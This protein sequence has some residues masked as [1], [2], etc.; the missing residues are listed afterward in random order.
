MA[1]VKM[2]Y[3]HDS[4]EVEIPDRNL[5]DVLVPADVPKSADLIGCL[6]KNLE[7]PAGTPAFSALCAGRRKVCVMVCD[8]TRP[9]ETDKILPTM[10]DK[11]GAG[12][13]NAEIVILVALGTHRPLSEGEIDRVVGREIGKKYAVVNHDA[14]D[15]SRL[16]AVP[17][18]RPD[19]P[20]QV[21]SLLVESDFRLALGAVK[22]HPVFGWSGGGK[23]VIP[24]VSGHETIGISHW[25]SCPFK[26]T[27]IMGRV[28][29]PVR[30]EAEAIV[31]KNNLLD[32]VVNAVLD[33]NGE[34]HDLRCGD[35][36][37]AHRQ[38]VDIARR[39]Y[40]RDIPQPAD[41][42]LVGAGKWAPDLW[43]GSMSV[44]QSEFFVKKGGTIVLFGNFP[45]GVGR[46][47]PEILEWGYRPYR[48]V[49]KL[50]EGGALAN[51]LTLAAHLVHLGR[52]LD[53]REAKCLLLSEGISPSDA[54]RLGFERLD[55][56]ERAMERLYRLHGRDCRVLA[57]PGFNSTPIVS[58]HPVA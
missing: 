1:I 52:V 16:A 42:V 49:K 10:L 41:A 30:L 2:A 31:A 48:E 6:G 36:I 7:N 5:M 23:I 50:V 15:E 38:C 40:L 39:F 24:G 58:E 28:D 37:L 57:I 14:R 25:N 20:V 27:E 12:S 45:E 4:L 46:T 19:F 29:N 13:P 9:M 54:G 3:F 34:I 47:H 8:L 35:P 56:P 53:A 33:E 51:D 43:V 18:P 32:F 26:G 21:N 22:P 55:S 11:I 44:Y 17:G